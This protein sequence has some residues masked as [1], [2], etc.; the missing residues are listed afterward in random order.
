MIFPIARFERFLNVISSEKY[1]KECAPL[2]RLL[3]VNPGSVVIEVKQPR[4]FAINKVSALI[5]E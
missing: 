5:Q 3:A 4:R 2:I 1:R